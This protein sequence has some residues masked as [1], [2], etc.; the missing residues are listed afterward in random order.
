MATVA[1]I[2]DFRSEQVQLFLI[3]KSPGYFPQSFK[4]IG[5]LVQEKQLEI[6]F[7]DGG[8]CGHLGFPVRVILIFLS[9]SFP[10]AS[11]QVSSQ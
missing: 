2:F 11:N 7:Q 1:A 4:S 5:I 6:D 3:C 10:D 8:R 9:A